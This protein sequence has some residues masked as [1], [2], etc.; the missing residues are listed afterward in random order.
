[1]KAFQSKSI[2]TVLTGL[3]GLALAGAQGAAFA[4]PGGVGGLATAQGQASAIQTA[5]YAVVG[6]LAAIYLIWLGVMAWADKKN[7]G[8]FGMG[9]VYVALVGASGVLATWAWGMF[10]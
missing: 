7:W 1:M 10:T 6:V 5:L 3:T 9:V 8:D 4:T 2:R